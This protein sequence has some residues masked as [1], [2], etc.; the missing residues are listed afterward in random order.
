M[1]CCAVLPLHLNHYRA[2]SVQ[3]LVLKVLLLV[4][5]FTEYPAYVATAQ[6]ERHLV[7]GD[8]VLFNRQ[9]SLHKMSMMVRLQHLAT[10]VVL[11]RGSRAVFLSNR[12]S[13][14]GRLA[15]STVANG[16]TWNIA[17]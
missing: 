10:F 1:M 2:G 3:E 8:Y 12:L 9:P 6:V 5:K 7:N 13:T 15:P 17:W 16:F 11:H 14:L 4:H